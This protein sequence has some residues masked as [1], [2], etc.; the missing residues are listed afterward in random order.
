MGS[1]LGT[2]LPRR[3]DGDR[4][5]AR[6]VSSSPT[7]VWW[8]GGCGGGGGSDDMANLGRDRGLSGALQRGAPRCTPPPCLRVCHLRP[9][10]LGRGTQARG[11]LSTEVTFSRNMPGLP[12]RG[13]VPP[14]PCGSHG[15][16]LASFCWE[17]PAC[18]VTRT[19]SV[20]STSPVHSTDPGTLRGTESIPV[21]G[22]EGRRQRGREAGQAGFS[23]S[24]LGHT[25]ATQQT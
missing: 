22:R 5:R 25:P 7:E 11:S 24:H 4:S 23:A 19:P 18:P 9:T 2:T 6:W 14:R 17:M 20:P 1:G 16:P 12:Q 10:A 13:Q 21:R 15:L 8:V 3:G